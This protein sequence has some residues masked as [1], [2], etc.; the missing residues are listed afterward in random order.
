MTECLIIGSG[1]VGLVTAYELRKSGCKITVI[2]SQ[3]SGQAS[4]SAAGILFPIN[5][6]ENK[7]NMQ[8]L[9][10][11]GH[12]EYNLFFNYFSKKEQDK[13]GLE[14][15]DLLQKENKNI[16]KE[17]GLTEKRI[18]SFLEDFNNFG[19]LTK[20]VVFA[21]LRYERWLDLNHS[22]KNE[23]KAS[24]LKELYHDYNLNSLLDEYPETRVRFFMMTCLKDS[25]DNLNS[26]FQSII[27]DM[28]TKNL[29]PWNLK[30]RIEEILANTKLNDNDKFFLARMLYPHIDAADYVELVKTNKGDKKNLDLVFK[31]EDSKGKIFT[32]RPPFQP[33]E[34]AKFQSIISKENLSVTFNA[35]HEFLF[36]VN[37]RNKVIGGLYYKIK[38][39]TRVHLEWVVIMKKYQ[40]RNLSKRLMDDFF[41]RIKQGGQEMITVGFY[42]ESFFYKQ[43][44]SI[45]Q[46]FG[47]LVKKL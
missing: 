19:V 3:R 31:T 2:E 1:I 16:F 23:A 43:G 21:A 47:G 20:P 34:I 36:L 12:K 39:K 44:F 14:K 46:S 27:K 22:A 8:D 32:I 40:R 41:N 11:A 9:C 5:P 29:S 42:H 45:D 30:D 7:K 24:I 18:N 33:K 25:V 37:D 15:K 38:N 26:Y 13:I 28:R 17:L 10:I 6:W 4:K 35:N